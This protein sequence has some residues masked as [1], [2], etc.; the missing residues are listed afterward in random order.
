MFCAGIS[1]DGAC[2]KLLDATTKA[3]LGLLH[4]HSDV[5][6]AFI[7][8][9]WN[10]HKIVS[11][12]HNDTVRIWDLTTT[13]ELACF[14]YDSR[15]S[16]I[17]VVRDSES[18]APGE[19][20]L[21]KTKRG[22]LSMRN[23]ETHEKMYDVKLSSSLRSLSTCV[24]GRLMLAVDHRNDIFVPLNTATGK[25]AADTLEELNRACS[26]YL[27]T[28]RPYWIE[29]C[30]GN[31]SILAIGFQPKT[32]R[33]WFCVAY[34][35]VLLRLASPTCV[36][37]TQGWTGNDDLSMNVVEMCF[38]GDGSKLFC[39][40]R[41]RNFERGRI[42]VLDTDTMTMIKV[43]QMEL[44]PSAHPVNLAAS[45][46]GQEL[47]FIPERP[48]LDAWVICAVDVDSEQVVHTLNDVTSVQYSGCS[49]VLM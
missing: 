42:T 2:I 17:A 12:G 10:D 40:S 49:H 18:A 23:L 29:T 44:R 8:F 41:E 28:K 33:E 4:S 9:P 46:S 45:Y 35:V 6:E 24:E 47:A 19:A 34:S 36:S 11:R 21:A 1:S 5:V 3:P 32:D 15:V 26:T 25:P 43:M 30:S 48:G 22:I 7:F 27:E 16:W 20:L 31:D 13:E 14:R 38:S 37:S 39:V